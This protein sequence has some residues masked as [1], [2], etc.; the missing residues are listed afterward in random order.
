[1]T[2]LEVAA[3]LIEFIKAGNPEGAIDTLY[4]PDIV[5]IEPEGENR[6]MRG[7]ESCKHKAQ[8]FNES[9]ELHGSEVDGPYPN[10]DKF[11]LLLNYDVTHRESGARFPMK[12]VALYQ[13]KDD[14]IVWEKFF[15]TMPG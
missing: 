12:E 1:M 15:Y 3:K 8:W 13:V 10:D 4:H 14:K 6:E 2:T 11:A 7:V 9:F 5:T